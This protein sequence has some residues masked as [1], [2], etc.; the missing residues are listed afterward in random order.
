MS[1]SHRAL[2][3]GITGQDGSYLAEL[4]LSKGYEVHGMLRRTSNLSSRIHGLLDRHNDSDGRLELHYGDM[5]DTMSLVRLLR[6]IQPHEVY[7]LAAQSHVQISFEQPN[8]TSEI[9][10]LGVLRILEAIREL[11]QQSGNEVRFYQASS[12]EMFGN[13]PETPQRETTPFAPRSPYGVAKLYGHWITVNYRES[14]GL[15]ASSG[16]LFNHESPRR[17]ENFVTRKVTQAAARIK[18]GLQEKVLLGNLESKRDWGFAG[19]FVYAMWLMLQQDKP[20]DYVIAT[21]VSHSVRELCKY[22]FNYVGLDYRD[23]VEYDIQFERPA[24]VD[25]LA[26]DATK[27]QETLGWKPTL[28]FQDLIAMMVESDLKNTRKQY[29]V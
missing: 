6:N 26:G 20:A 10:G 27:A 18:L 15:H 13:V 16:I 12:S 28:R 1:L 19:D 9:S 25:A 21:G 14:Y 11:Q 8:Y 5:A 23:Y 24:E 29:N 4:L 2:I 3:T 17:G 7:N 22:A